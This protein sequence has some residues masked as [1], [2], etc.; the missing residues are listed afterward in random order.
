MVP[1]YARRALAGIMLALT[2]AIG[3]GARAW[4]TGTLDFSPD[5]PPS[6]PLFAPIVLSGAPQLTSLSLA[7][8]TVTDSTGSGAGWHVI[9]TVSD[10]TLGSD[11][12]PASE[13][14]L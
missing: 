11:D 2:V 5:G 4:A 6:F 13:R 8:F 12:I 10:L 14:A 9:V 1:R 7:P 3:G